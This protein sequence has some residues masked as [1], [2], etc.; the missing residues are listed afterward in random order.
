[1]QNHLLIFLSV[2][3]LFS[4]SSKEPRQAKKEIETATNITTQSKK[5]TQ[6]TTPSLGMTMDELREKY[7]GCEF[8]EEPV[9]EYGI[10][11]ESLGLL[12]RKDNEDLFFAWAIPGENI[13]NGITLLSPSFVIDG[14]VH[15]G[16]SVKSFFEK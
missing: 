14:N 10:D 12:I 3:L 9:F 2:A 15:V 7:N 4:C 1:M 6:L 5:E 8:I 11:G 16:M 13:I